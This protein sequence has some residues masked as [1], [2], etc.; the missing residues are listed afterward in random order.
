MANDPR[1][2]I[3]LS[4]SSADKDRVRDYHRTLVQLGY[5]PW[6][7]EE[8]M[9]A[10]APLERALLEGMK[11]SMAAVFFITETFSDKR[12]L[13]SEIDYAIGEKTSRGDE[14][15]I[16]TLVLSADNSV[17]VPDLLRRFVWK[18]PASDLEGIREILRS[19]P[20]KK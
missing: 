11:N 2:N 1:N 20:T 8:A 5:N 17:V 13:S 9:A 12:Y 3:F 4:H 14:F 10:G 16:I 19:L 6:L 7:D 15:S 18:K